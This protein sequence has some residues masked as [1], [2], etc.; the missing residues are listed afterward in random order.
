[1]I[2]HSLLNA[3]LTEFEALRQSFHQKYDSLFHPSL[4]EFGD[5]T[6]GIP[7]VLSWGEPSRL[8]PY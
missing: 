2:K 6:Y 8:T 4:A 5:F 1:M 7:Q 3:G